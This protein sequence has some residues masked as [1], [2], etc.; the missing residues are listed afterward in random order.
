[1]TG[2]GANATIRD[3]GP[4]REN[5]GCSVSNTDATLLCSIRLYVAGQSPAAAGVYAH[6]KSVCDRYLPGH[7]QLDVIDVSAEAGTRNGDGIR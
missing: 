6:L 5:G 2:V 1:M 3:L 7:Y 4:D